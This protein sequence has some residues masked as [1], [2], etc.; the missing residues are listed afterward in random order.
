MTFQDKKQFF[1][2]S[3]NIDSVETAEFH[4]ENCAVNVRET[5]NARCLW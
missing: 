4:L 1:G 3:E 5:K 2:Q